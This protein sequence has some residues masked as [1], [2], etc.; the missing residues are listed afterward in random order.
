MSFLS[1]LFGSKK[2]IEAGINGLDALVF[3]DEERSDK[4]LLFL[5]M[6]EPFKLAQRYIAMTFCPAYVICWV[7]TF[8]IEVLDVF[9]VKD[10]NTDTLYSLL[11]GDMAVM[12]VV[13][14][15]FYFSGGAVEG[16]VNRFKK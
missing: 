4:K 12:V 11:Q 16:I 13:I 15:T 14:L 1:G 10:L 7:L 5:K 6:Y 3:T 2:V 8:L 9:M